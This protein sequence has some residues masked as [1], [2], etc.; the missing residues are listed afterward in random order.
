MV[1]RIWATGFC[2]GMSAPAVP[3]C[4]SGRQP[5]GLARP[6]TSFHL[7]AQMKGGKAKGPNTACSRKLRGHKR[8]RL[9]QSRSTRRAGAPSNGDPGDRVARDG[10]AVTNRVV[11]AEAIDRIVFRPFALVTFIWARK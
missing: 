5:A 7:R 4:R 2:C 1:P 8:I 6:A 11:V 9:I 10:T 3:L